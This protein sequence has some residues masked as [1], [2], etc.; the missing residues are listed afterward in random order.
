MV[1]NKEI[2]LYKQ[3]SPKIK[4][5]Q[6]W[7]LLDMTPHDGQVGLIDSFD[8]DDTKNCFVL[9]LGRRAQTLDTLI[10]TPYGKVP[11]RDLKEGQ[12]IN[13][14]N[15]GT[16]IVTQL[17]PIIVDDVYRV[18]LQDGR[19]IDVNAEHLFTVIDHH[20]RTRTLPV[21]YLLKYYKAPRKNNH[22]PGEMTIEYKFKIKNPKPLLKPE[23]A[24]I[25]PPYSLGLLLGDGCLTSRHANLGMGD[26]GPLQR[27]KQETACPNII[28]EDKPN[29]FI[30]SCG[31]D[32]VDKLKKLNLLGTTSS[33]K[34]IPTE[35]LE[36]SASQ[37][38][39][40]LR[41]LIDTDGYV[42]TGK[43]GKF[44]YTE[45]VTVS[46][47]LADDVEELAKS[48]GANVTR[49]TKVPTFI[50]STGERKEGQLAYRLFITGSLEFA[51]LERKQ[52]SSRELT[53]NFITNIER[54]P[55]QKEMRC[56]SVSSPDQLYVAND[57]VVT[58]NSGKSAQ[59]S[60]VI[61][62]E[63][64][65]P[66][67]STILLAPTFRNA[68]IIFNEVLKLVRQLNLPITKM[69][70]NN[71]TLTLENGATFSALSESN[72][73]AGLGSRCSLLVVDETQSI[74]TILHIFETL[75]GPMLL[76]FGVRPSGILE[77]N[78]VFLGT[79]RGVG[80]PF[81]ELFLYELTRKNWKSFSSPS[82]VNPVLPKAYLEEQKDQLS[83]RAYREEILAEW[84]TAGA[85]VFYA[86][87]RDLN[88]YDPYKID[89]KGANYILGHDFGTLDSTALVYVYVTKAG[90]YYVHD[91]YMANSRTTANHHEEFR[92]VI[93]KDPH[94][95]CEGS[96]GDPSAAQTMM[97]LRE[98]YRYDI[99][100]GFNKI[101]PG[102]ATINNLMEPQGLNRRP[103]LF[104]NQNL[105][106]LITQIQLI[107]YRNEAGPQVNNG[108]PFSRHKEHHFDLVHAMRYA[109]AT[110]F[111]QSNA[112]LAFVS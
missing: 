107:T 91:A 2:Q 38:L 7:K 55:E 9:T 78:V 39:E 108:D 99:Q 46:K 20:R 102:I 24:L 65:V 88:L 42:S 103:K 11:V 94:A 44:G 105:T 104:I 51:N 90:D 16:Q 72:V 14:V 79:P 111:R 58:H 64:L 25:I 106:E 97:D 93:A 73:E 110:H 98:T 87:D 30:I 70:K 50:T 63:L 61:I 23:K 41:G 101:A 31:V 5:A 18:T 54:L 33:T 84:L 60:I 109:I 100:K 75:I 81:H 71:F 69:N 112:A 68:E 43:K 48:L 86:F 19:S 76:D 62:R 77:A 45:Y 12:E 27:F 85:G 10:H 3:V 13:D 47:Q 89:L 59:A 57:Y 34:F 15:G 95:Q 6:V 82:Y 1:Q 40:L 74:P 66:F 17:H 83:E 56:I 28:R 53:Y 49:S 8:N 52:G 92:K 35:Y 67:S 80:T 26:L 36:A 21:K 32:L 96:Y 29:Y 4:L 37:R 22:K